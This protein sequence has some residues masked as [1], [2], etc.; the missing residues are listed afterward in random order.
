MFFF[1]RNE[2]YGMPSITLQLKS[3]LDINEI[4][5]KEMN[6]DSTKIEYGVVNLLVVQLEDEGEP[7]S[8]R[9]GILT[10]LEMS[11]IPSNNISQI[12]FSPNL[13]IHMQNSCKVAL[14]YAI[15][16]LL[17]KQKTEAAKILQANNIMVSTPYYD[18]MNDGASGG[19]SSVC[20]FI[21]LALKKI[22]SNEVA[23]TGEV[24]SVGQ[25]YRIG[26]LKEKLDAANN[27][28]KIKTVFLPLENRS[29]YLE[30]E[31]KQKYRFNLNFVTHFEDVG[32]NIFPEL[33][34]E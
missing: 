24:S 13:D 12:C 7:T 30:I 3:G 1:S 34:D 15:K 28:R 20:A 22:V 27:Y 29:D 32:K 16:L 8:K 17:R 19:I 14:H 11:I 2:M 9:Y 6:I 4:V 31:T 26:G 23:F 5:M 33:F 18:F 25:I 21:S 10:I